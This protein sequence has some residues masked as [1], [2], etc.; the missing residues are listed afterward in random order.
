MCTNT[1]QVGSNMKL[2]V[3]HR[4]CVYLLKTT[5]DYDCGLNLPERRGK[6]SRCGSVYG[7]FQ[8]EQLTTPV[9]SSTVHTAHTDYI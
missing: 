5:N 1:E 2:R 3:L 8:H 9:P 7:V 4:S 6:L